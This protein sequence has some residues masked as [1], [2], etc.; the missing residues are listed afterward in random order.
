MAVTTYASG[1]LSRRRTI[2]I[3]AN[4]CQ[5]RVNKSEL[6]RLRATFPLIVSLN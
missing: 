2:E 1:H 5:S 3:G 6:Y 4:G